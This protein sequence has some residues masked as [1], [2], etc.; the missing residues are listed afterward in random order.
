M[1]ENN[2]KDVHASFQRE[3]EST[4]LYNGVE[5]P[6]NANDSFKCIP[7]LVERMADEFF[8]SLEFHSKVLSVR[9]DLHSKTPS[10][11]SKAVKEL[12]QWLKQDLN[13]SYCMKNIGH[14]WVYEYGKKKGAHWHL[15]LLLDGNKVQNS[16]SVTEKIKSYWQEVRDLGCL[17]VPRNCYTQ[18]LRGDAGSF[19]EAFYRSSYLCKER[20]KFVG[21]KRCFGSSRLS[22]KINKAS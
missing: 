3:R 1:K 17:A 19:D 7:V 2:S 22:N 20:S 15:V 4:Y 6:L 12:L 18:I 9:V 5:L 11:D 13:R 16:W 8:A 14:F 10:T 21:N